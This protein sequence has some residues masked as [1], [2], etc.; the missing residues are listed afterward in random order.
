V[1]AGAPA[2]ATAADASSI[3]VTGANAQVASTLAIVEGAETTPIS[4]VAPEHEE[5]PFFERVGERMVRTFA[6]VR[7]TFEYIGDVTAAFAAA[8]LHPRSVRWRDVFLYMSRAGADALPI[9]ALIN[10]LMGVILAFQGVNLLG[11][12]GFDSYTPDAVAVSVVLE[13]GPLMTAIIVAGRSGSAFAAEIGTMTVNEEVDA[14]R[15]MGL[16][17]TRFLVVPKIIALLAMMPLLVVFA[18]ACG[19]MGGLLIGTTALDMTIAQYL[20]QSLEHIDLWGA[21]QGLIKGEAYAVC[22]ASV[23]CLRGLQTR[24]GAQGVGLAAT[25]AVVSSIFLVIVCDAILTVIFHYV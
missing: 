3:P 9:V 4:A 15:T 1:S 2:A 17:R 16:D 21:S 11:K 5:A 10:G 19:L 18:D 25:S 12:L 22:I 13:L 8:A 6:S 20:R 24:Q 23:G 7:N 14:L